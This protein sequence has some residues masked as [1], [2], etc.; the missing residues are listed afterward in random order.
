M[1]KP[2][3]MTINELKSKIINDCNQSGL[4]PVILDLIVQGIYLE[5]HRLAEK[6]SLEEEKIYKE[7]IES[8]KSKEDLEG[9][10]NESK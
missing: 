6:Q 3:T 5:I 7:A 8:E 2:I 1:D 4:P 9:K 10:G